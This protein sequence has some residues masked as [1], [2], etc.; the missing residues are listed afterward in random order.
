L[1][2]SCM[3]ETSGIR[4][5]RRLHDMQYADLATCRPSMAR[6]CGDSNIEGGTAVV[7]EIVD[8]DGIKTWIVM[9]VR[10]NRA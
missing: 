9:C 4:L 3:P 10:K 1:S 7:G 2:L 6:G 8:E 5:R